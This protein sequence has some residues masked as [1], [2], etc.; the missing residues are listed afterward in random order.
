[1]C[2]CGWCG[3]IFAT[4]KPFGLKGSNADAALIKRKLRMAIE[5][6]D[7]RDDMNMDDVELDEE[8]GSTMETGGTYDFKHSNIKPLHICHGESTKSLAITTKKLLSQPQWED[9]MSQVD[10]MTSRKFLQK[11][12]W[13]RANQRKC[14]DAL[15]TCSKF[16]IHCLHCSNGF[17][18][19][20]YI[21][22]YIPG[23]FS[24][25]W[26]YTRISSMTTKLER[27]SLTT[28]SGLPPT[29]PRTFPLTITLGEQRQKG[30]L[31]FTS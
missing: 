22:I 15:V 4:K 7:E 27:V 18:C 9:G 3:D 31:V 2:C 11:D 26:S 21:Y 20:I 10:K 13:G 23:L 8:K 14:V 25:S 1:M 29:C 19:L 24:E 5:S 12:T 28:S 30:F 17:L 6:N 16:W